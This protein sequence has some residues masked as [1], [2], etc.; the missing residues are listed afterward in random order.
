M[1]KVKKRTRWSR[2]LAWMLSAAM[3]VSMVSIP[4]KAEAAAIST[5]LTPKNGTSVSQT[6]SGSTTAVE[7]RYSLPSGYSTYSDLK[8]AG[9]T[10]IEFTYN[11]KQYTALSGET[12]GVQPFVN[13]DVTTGNWKSEWHNLTSS[14]GTVTLSLAS[15]STGMESTTITHVGLQLANVTGQCEMEI[16]S[17]KLTGSDSGSSGGGSG[18]GEEVTGNEV[19]ATVTYKLDNQYWA[20]CSA[21]IENHKS[22][23]VSGI[24]IVIPFTGT[25]TGIK[26]F[27]DAVTAVYSSDVNGVIL[28]YG[29]TVAAGG[30]TASTEIKFGYNPTNNTAN[31]S[32]AY[33]KAI[34][35]EKPGGSTGGSGDNTGT[36]VTDVEYNYAKL[37]QESLYLYDAN[38]CGPQVAD[39]TGLSWRGNCHTEDQTATYNGQTVDVSGG[40]HDAGDHAK[41]ALPQAYSAS[42]LGMGYYQFK[43]AFD[44][45]GQT[46]HMKTILDHFAD[47]L[48]RCAVLDSNGNVI[49]YC[50]QVGNGGTDHDYWGA[51]EN[52]PSRT[53]Q[54]YFTSDSN[55]CVDVLCEVAAALAIHA[56]NFQDDKALSYAK[57]LFAYADSQ[58]VAGRTGLSISDPGNLYASDSYIDDY[59]LAAA[60]LYKATN[61]SSYQQK[62]NEKFGAEGNPDW[63]L[64]WN[65]VKLAAMLYGP[66]GT[67]VSTVADCLTS[68][69]NSKTN[70]SDNGYFFLQEWGSA[71]YNVAQQFMALAYDAVTGKQQY[72][73]WANGQMKYILG[74][75][76]GNGGKGYCY[77]VGYNDHSVLYPHHRAASGYYNVDSNGTTKQAHV[78]LGAL[79][80]GPRTTSAAFVDNASDYVTAEVALDYNATLVGAAAG[81][82]LLQKG[83]AEAYPTAL[84]TSEELAA[85][86][87][88]KYYGADQP[89][90]PAAKLAA[91]AVTCTALTYGYESVT[92][93][94]V[95]VSNTGDGD[96]TGITVSMQDGVA[97]VA[98]AA[99]D[100]V[101]AGG[102][103]TVTVTPKQGLAAGTYQ[104]TLVISYNT[105]KTLK[106]PVSI[107]VGKRQATVTADAKTRKYG[108]ENPV[109]TY[110]LSNVLAADTM[111]L[112]ISMETTATKTSDV[113]SYPI[114]VMASNPNYEI[115][116]K[117]STM[118]VEK[119]EISEV[120]FPT[121]GN[122]IETG[123]ALSAITLQGGD[124]QYGTFA[125]KDGTQTYDKAGTYSADVVMTISSAVSKNYDFSKIKGYADGKVVRAVSF[126]VNKKGTPKIELP[127]AADAVYGQT[128]SEVA[129]TGGSTK[130][131]SFAWKDASITL[132][133]VGTFAYEI[134]FTPT[135][136]FKQEYETADSILYQVNVKVGKAPQTKQAGKPV[137]VSRTAASVLVQAVSGCEYSADNGATWQTA[138]EIGNLR[139][140][141]AYTIVAR[142]AATACYEAGPVSD[143]LAVYTLA[144]DP[145]TIDI[146]RLS[147]SNYVD[148]IKSVTAEGEH[149]TIRYE[150]NKL[151]LIDN[152]SVH[153]GG[154]TITG[155]NEDLTIIC[156]SGEYTLILQDAKFKELDTTATSKASVSVQGDTKVANGLPNQGGNTGGN[157]GGSTGGNTG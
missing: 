101:A 70:T 64:C 32:G 59:A 155:N 153:P 2:M 60:W 124:T 68:T 139:E 143:G 20:E 107:T 92:A 43:Q 14:T 28:Y 11:V 5:D 3:A 63:V 152:D 80:G 82:Y 49:S 81:L 26:T 97:F 52:Q 24:Q 31:A 91:E 67:K 22:E 136:A 76:A 19:T 30:S 58:I 151:T 55:P 142:Y 1:K 9:Y 146:G 35:A 17:A 126:H 88:T 149:A 130:Y 145:Y 75:N 73:D 103:M 112:N 119:A 54:V 131:G 123:G 72:S 33:V 115:I 51:P 141:T 138:A 95:T 7:L 113:G 144:S 93:S 127:Q 83:N 56:V 48:E 108:E 157:T 135:N 109:L 29:G 78:L 132:S 120:A 104:D 89:T 18:S 6:L 13:F 133:E 12:V 40:F 69:I 134:V 79:V 102:T 106:V 99:T 128:L 65:N 87:V 37:L 74:N 27:D 150:G 110:T 117:D 129:L 118:N 154:Y 85:V 121:A 90:V 116:C 147:D 84:A 21:V 86:G 61:E 125:W 10:A 96:A 44:E 122:D 148:A 25:P 105:T 15:V 98:A 62:Y 114:T 8:A 38:M 47:Y 46:E 39:K 100:S 34:N 66:A 111:K 71:R 137:L 94:D 50:Y 140:L 53:G 41:F 42:A 57:K 23:A 36:V 156:G 45:L 16:T 4:K 77:V